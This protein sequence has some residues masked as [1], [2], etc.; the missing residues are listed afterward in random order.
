MNPNEASRMLTTRFTA[1]TGCTV[2]IQQAPMNIATP[3]LA[4]AVAGAGGLGMLATWG[5]QGVPPERI[6][7]VFD[8][9]PRE[10]PGAYGANFVLRFL[11]PDLRD[12]CLRAAAERARVVECFYTD[13][14][15][16]VVAVVHDAGALASWQVGSREEALAAQAAGCDFIVAQGTEAGGHVRGTIGLLALLDEVLGAVEVPVVAAGG[17][18]SGRAMAAALAA[19]ADGVRVGTRFIAADETGAHPRYLE[20]LFAA[21]ASDS[22]LT[23]AFWAGWPDAPHRVLRSSITAAEALPDGPIGE[24]THILTGQRYPVQRFARGAPHRGMSGEIDAMALYAGESVGGVTR[25]QPAAEIVQE[26]A[27]EAER[28]LRRWPA[29]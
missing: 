22:V 23:D 4:A 9:L 3:A 15:P 25:V 11:A 12:A 14:D 19:G 20:R 1:L 5:A 26:L 28:L 13:P 8:Q 27:G 18:G 2:P 10:V 7:A 17:I 29:E 6:A 24:G 16:A 21:R